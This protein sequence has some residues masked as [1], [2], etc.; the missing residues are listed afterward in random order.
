MI[1]YKGIHPSGV[2][3][4]IV[5]NNNDY[6]WFIS[7]EDGQKTFNGVEHDLKQAKRNVK[8]KLTYV[9]LKKE[10]WRSKISWVQEK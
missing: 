8:E 9:T 5:E 10:F 3:A 4:E 2:K 1:I 7:S 6:E